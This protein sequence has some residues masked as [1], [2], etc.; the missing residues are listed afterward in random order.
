MVDSP[1]YSMSLKA[2]LLSADPTPTQALDELLLLLPLLT[3][4]TV[5]TLHTVLRTGLLPMLLRDLSPSPPP[6]TGG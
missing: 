6:H 5:L 3:E 1:L 2:L 4:Q